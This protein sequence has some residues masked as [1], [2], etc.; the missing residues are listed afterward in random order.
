MG[1]ARTSCASLG[2]PTADEELI[3]LAVGR[4][5]P[6]GNALPLARDAGGAARRLDAPCRARRSRGERSRARLRRARRHGGARD[7]ADLTVAGE[8]LRAARGG[9][10]PSICKRHQLLRHAAVPAVQHADDDLLADVAALGERNRALLDAGFERNGVL[11][12]VDAEQR[13]AGLD[14]RGLERR[15]GPR[16]PAPAALQ[17][18]EQRRSCAASTIRRQKPGTPSWSMRA[19]DTGVPS[20][21]AR[22]LL[23]VGPLGQPR[24][25]RSARA[26]DESPRRAAREP[27]RRATLPA[28]DLRAARPR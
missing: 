10:A 19:T 7:V 25:A 17:A 24:R 11:G 9:T 5:G 13:I 4:I 28:S 27:R 8:Q 3:T 12:H 16:A 1:G 6:L 21:S 14:A 20:N 2:F 22:A 15:V 18:L 26:C 23:I